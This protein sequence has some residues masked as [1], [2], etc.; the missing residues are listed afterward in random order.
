MNTY[1]P[2]TLTAIAELSKLCPGT[3]TESEMKKAVATNHPLLAA[4]DSMLRAATI[5]KRKYDSAISSDYVL[6]D[7]WL[8]AAVGIR[9]LLNGDFG[10]LD[11]GTVESVFWSAMAEAGYSGSD[12]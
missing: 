6:G 3:I 7:H 1:A 11:N 8:K 12:I 10:P 4:M 9:E 5:H 2:E